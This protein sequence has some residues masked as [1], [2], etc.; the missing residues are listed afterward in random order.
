MLRPARGC[1]LQAR[2]V[3]VISVV[4]V[5]LIGV[6]FIVSEGGLYTILLAALV[7][8]TTG[9]VVTLLTRRLLLAVVVMVAQVV[10]VSLA[11]W[12]KLKYMNMVVHAYDLAFYLTSSTTLSFLWQSY[13]LPMALT[14]LAMLAAI[15]AGVVAYRVDPVRVGRTRAAGVA[16]ALSA[17]VWT[18]AALTEERRH[19]LFEYEGMYLSSF[20]RSWAETIETLWRGQLLE[21][22]PK[23]SAPPLRLADSCETKARPPHIILIHHES[24]VQPSLFAGLDYDRRLDPFL[25]GAAVAPLD[26]R[27]APFL[28]LGDEP[29]RQHRENHLTDPPAPLVRVVLVDVAVGFEGDPLPVGVPPVRDDERRRRAG[30]RLLVPRERSHLG[31]II[32]AGE[33]PQAVVDVAPAAGQL[34]GQVDRGAGHGLPAPGEPEERPT[35]QGVLVARPPHLRLRELDV[36]G[37]PLRDLDRS[38]HLG[39]GPRLFDGGRLAQLVGPGGR[40]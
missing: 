17:G 11:S 35:R 12:L 31:V 2:T 38:E 7:C 6:R 4:C 30:V 16:L 13:R 33:L 5:L 10:L 25:E 21:A 39:H 29:H 22:A 23:A 19:S 40:L 37:H 14:I 20:Y 24:V 1:A 15:G 9:A 34:P 26:R 28:C 36:A 8:A 18:T 27:P 3:Y 32:P